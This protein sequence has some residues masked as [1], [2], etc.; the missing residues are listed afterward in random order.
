MSEREPQGI[1]QILPDTLA[2]KIAAGEVVQ[3]PASV[4]KELLENAIDAGADAVTLI[5]KK[6]GRELVQV[7]DNGCGMGPTDAVA[8]FQ[9]HATSKIQ[10]IEDLQQL[11]T[12]GFRG[13]ALAS[14]ASVAQVELRTKRIADPAGTCIQV[15]GGAL[16]TNEPCAAPDG[17]SI[18]VR[19]LFYNVPARRNFLKSNATEF[20]HLVETFQFV[21][22]SNPQLGFTLI[23]DGHEVHQLPPAAEGTG[24]RDALHARVQGLFGD[25][26]AGH[27]VPVHEATSYMSVEGFVAKPEFTRRTRGEQFFFVNQRYIKNRLLDHAVTNAYGE[28]LPKGAYPFFA[29]FLQIDPKHVDVNVH[30]TKAEVKFDDERG[31]YGFILAIIRKALGEADITPNMAF[32]SK[33]RLVEQAGDGASWQPQAQ[34]ASPASA[35]PHQEWRSASPANP[36]Q[37]YA[38]LPGQNDM[39]NA[40]ARPRP[41]SAGPGEPPPPS[42]DPPMAVTVAASLPEGAEVTQQGQGEVLLWQLHDKYILARIRS[43]VMIVDQH[44][45]HERIL[46][47]KALKAMESQFGMT[48]QL[49]FPHTLEFT[50]SDFELLTELGPDLKGL[51]F[52]IEFFGGRSVIVRGVP[53]DIQV[54]DEREILEAIL[55]QYK[56]YVDQYQIRGRDNLAK[57]VSCRTAIKTG[58]K[59]SLTEMQVLIDQL[60]MCKMPYACPHGRPTM[61]KISLDE[62]DRRFGRVGH[63]ERD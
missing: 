32:G 41:V 9:R 24:F 58:K 44:A 36:M 33:G 28:M 22:L 49:L 46:Y 47:E 18:A 59:L 54:G 12:L 45:A 30:P 40:G 5:L 2:N 21:A 50:P 56:T 8:C 7:I 38:H 19:N 10:A 55:Q 23:H 53:A 13:E 39:F 4:A 3:R 29:L 61:I 17:T 20:K 34:P 63:L 16:L 62:L 42:T 11:Y 60:F 43:G 6:A 35:A 37:D 48:Q 14:I 25:K 15:E 27:L 57:S 1:I 31:V 51:G 52:D 26:T